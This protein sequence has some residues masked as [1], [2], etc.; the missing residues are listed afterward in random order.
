MT[1]IETGEELRAFYGA[2]STLGAKKDMHHIDR[3]ARVH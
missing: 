1:M 2:P 3:H